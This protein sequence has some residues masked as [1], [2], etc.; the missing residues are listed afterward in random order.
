MTRLRDLAKLIRSKNA[1]P[2]QLTIDVL[3]DDLA[4]YRRV[5]ESG[6]LSAQPIAAM[7]HLDPEVVRVYNYEPGL[8][9][10]VT[11]PRP[12]VSGD[13][14]DSDVTGGQQYGPLVDLEVPERERTSSDSTPGIDPLRGGHALLLRKPLELGALGG[15]RTGWEH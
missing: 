14:F 9:I 5:A 7:Y 8:A 13:I 4:T 6:V 1:G 15:R 12:V 11:F 2:F 3:F 10:K